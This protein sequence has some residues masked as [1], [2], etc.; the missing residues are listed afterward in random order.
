MTHL[1]RKRNLLGLADKAVVFG[2]AVSSYIRSTHL[3]V[4]VWIL[5][6]VYVCLWT[7]IRQKGI[8]R[9]RSCC[10]LPASQPFSSCYC[11]IAAP[12]IS[13]SPPVIKHHSDSVAKSTRKH[14]RP[15]VV[16][17]H[18]YWRRGKI[19]IVERLLD[20]KEN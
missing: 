11:E 15:R 6:Y 1:R 19:R 5:T 20:K 4:F 3:Y 12:C 9:R 14:V 7:Y 2:L 13:F 10:C 16:V 8:I 18:S 17:L